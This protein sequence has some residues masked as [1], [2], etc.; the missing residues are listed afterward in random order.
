MS[1]NRYISCEPPCDQRLWR[2]VHL[3]YITFPFPLVAIV[4]SVPLTLT[5]P[6]QK[7]PNK[8]S[9]LPN[10]NESVSSPMP[11]PPAQ[12]HAQGLDDSSRREAAAMVIQKACREYLD[13]KSTRESAKQAEQSSDAQLVC[14]DLKAPVGDAKLPASSPG[15]QDVTTLFLDG[16]DLNPHTA[17]TQFGRAEVNFRTFLVTA[18]SGGHFVRISNEAIA[19]LCKSRCKPGTGVDNETKEEQAA[20]TIQK[21][22]RKW[23]AAKQSRS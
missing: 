17:A 9:A 4:L 15:E 23:K 3:R 10:H 19:T 13:R 6:C 22:F 2:Q 7:S 8:M 1:P 16:A 20:R 18:S 14:L 21:A 12:T 11:F 5:L